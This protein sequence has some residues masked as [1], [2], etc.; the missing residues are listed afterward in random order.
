L[1]NEKFIQKNENFSRNTLHKK[2]ET[3]ELKKGMRME[4]TVAV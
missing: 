1:I 4:V 2:A 3:T